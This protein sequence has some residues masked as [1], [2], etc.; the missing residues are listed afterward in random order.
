LERLA[1][2][3]LTS[4]ALEAA[5]RTTR[6]QSMDVLSSQ[7]NIAGYKAVMMAADKYQRLFP[8]LMTAAGTIKAAR[9]VILGVGVAGLQAI[10]TAKRLGAV[11]EASDVRPS[12]KEQ[13]E[14]LGAKFIDVPYETAEEK[15]AAEGVGGY[16]RPM[17]PSWLERQK[18]EVAKRVAAADVVISTALIPGRAA[19]VLV[20]EDMVKA[21]K[22]GSVIVDMAAPAGG[23]CPLT[24]A[25]R[26]VVKHGVTIIGETNIPALVAADSS[27]LY[28]RNVLDFLKLVLPKEGGFTVPADDD[29]VMACLMTQSGEVKRK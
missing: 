26:T 4:F 21:M 29:I 25:G 15:E 5:P 12:V 24:E 28:A 17:P 3:G 20:T 13:V 7:A 9:V 2:A 16:A 14:S 19:P 27:S 10:A 22:P 6:A 11:I 23:N 18:V 1:A 8:M